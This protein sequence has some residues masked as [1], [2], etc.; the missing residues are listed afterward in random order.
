MMKYNV[1]SPSCSK[2]FRCVL[3]LPLFFIFFVASARRLEQVPEP[4]PRP[5]PVPQPSPKPKPSSSPGLTPAPEPK[6]CPCPSPSPGPAPTPAPPRTRNTTFPAIFAFGDSIVDTG[7]ND[8]ISTLV[9]AN[10][11][12]YGMNF[13]HGLP[14]GRFCNGKIPADFIAEFLG[15][16]PTLPPYLKPGL[17]H[18]DLVT[19]VSFASGG[20]GFDPLTPIVVSAIPMSNQLTYFQEYIEKVKGFVGKE[21]AEHIISKSL[22][23]VIAGS[24]DLANTYYGTHAEE[25]LYDIDA[26]TS[27]MASSASSFAMQLYESGAR[28]IGFIGVSPIGCIPIQRTARGGLKR[29]CFDEINVAAQL[30]NTKLSRSLHSVAETLK[31]ATLVYIDIYSLF[32][33]MIQNPKEYG[34]DEIDRG[35]CGTGMVELGPLCNQFTSLLCS[36]VSSYMFWD[37]YHPTERAYRILTKKFPQPKPP[38]APGPSACPPIPPRPQPKPPPAP[39]PSQCPPP[40]PQPKPP[41]PPGPSACPPKPQPKPPPA[42]GPSAC[43]PIPPKPQPKPPPAPAPSPCPPQPPK[44][45]PKPPPAPAPSPKPGPSPPPPKPPSP[46]PKPVPPPAPSPKPSPP[47]PS[48]KPKPSP[49][50]PL[51]PKPENKTIPA[52]FFFGDSIFDTGN[53]NNLKSKIKSNYRPYG[54]DFPSRVATGR[55]SNGKVASDYISTYLGVKE[56]VPAYLDQKLQQNQ[57]QR[58]DLL[59]GVSFASGGAGFDPETSESVEVIPMLDQLSYFQDYV[60]RVKKLVGKKEAKRI[61]SKGVAIV[62]AGG[63]DLIY[64]Y[65]G[66]GAQ[67]LKTDIDSYTTL[68]ADSAAS[69]VLQLYGYGARRIGVIGTPPLGCTPSQRV[70]DKKIC[71]EEINYAAQL[72]NSKLAIILDQLSETLRNST[73]VYMDIYSIFSKILESPAHYGFEEIKKPCCKIGLTGG[74]ILAF[75]DSILDTGNNN[76]LMTVSKSNFL[77]YGRNFPYHIPTGRFGNGRVLSDLVAEGL[78]IKNLVP[79][80]RSSFLKSSELPTG[81]C[82]ASGGSGLDK[83]TASIQGVIWVQ[84][85]LKDFQSYI[86]KLSQEVGDAAKVKEIIANAVVLISAGNNDIAITFFA[87]RAKKL[88]YNIETY[89]DQLIEWKTTFMQN[90]YNMGARKFAVLGTLPLGCLPGARQLSGDLICLP[91]VNH[92][93][94]IYNQKV[95]NLV[96]KFR[97]SLPDGKFVYIDMYNSL[98]DVIENPSKYGFRTA[99]PCCCSVMTPVPCLDSGSHVFWDFAHPSEKAYKAV[100]PNIVSVISNKLA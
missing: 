100:L 36:N 68:M 66:I 64:T 86:Q 73:L 42:P 67:H 50:A 32:A 4:S 2:L 29:K 3:F 5:A 12:P 74:A 60:K 91:H 51:P 17:T 10:F 30:F 38:P 23:I 95:A 35:C 92:G 33:H 93:A 34:F 19:G 53:N 6:P 22:A 26:Y 9:K 27:Y 58:S 94:K 87:T 55:F 69:F 52:V 25:L 14:T 89:T 98:L 72:F 59:T 78:G 61:V 76:K 39:G 85:Q 90:L 41:P 8:Y 46:V 43:P 70:K 15:V 18:E 57:L 1:V 63:T 96:V 99:K 48:P 82:F 56:I 75:G 11:P 80:F 21:K 24:D 49:P 45:Q 40:K 84:D 79:A 83:F 71:D 88:R 97:Q 20:S 16:K 65:F 31:N 54:M 77:P 81:V 37:S 13:P 47:A 62:V 44:P 7:N 28:K